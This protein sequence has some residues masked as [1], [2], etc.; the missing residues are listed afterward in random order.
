MIDIHPTHQRITN[1]PERAPSR[2]SV[3]L[4]YDRPILSYLW[5]ITGDEQTASELAQEIFLR[6]WQ[7][8]DKISTHEQHLGWLFR[9]A[10]NLALQ[11]QR[12]AG[13]MVT[14]ADA[15]DLV[16][17]DPSLHFVEQDLIR[18]TLVR[19]SFSQR[20]A[21]VLREIHRLSCAEI[22]ACSI[23]HVTPFK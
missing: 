16:S 13:S 1:K 17:S 4:S 21:L 22:E 8:F 2:S 12:R 23:Y 5:R 18:Q 15:A 9:V 19:L 6:A 7:H 14:L 11:Q 20:A 3:F 10:T